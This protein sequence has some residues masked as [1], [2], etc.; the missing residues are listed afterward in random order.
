MLQAMEKKVQAEGDKEEALF[1]KFMCYCNS[2]GGSLEKSIA[3]AGTKIPQVT[4]D[5][6]A[7][8]AKRAQLTEDL[9]TH[10]TDRDAA[11]S[12]MASA[13]AVR[14]KEAAEFA[15]EKSDAETNIAALNKATAAVEAGVAGFVQTD[16]AKVL[17]TF[18]SSDQ[19]IEDS[20][21]DQVL[22][23]LS[24]DQSS[25]GSIQKWLS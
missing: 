20:D 17:K 8:E 10:R 3:D 2:G 11:K 7:G 18:V 24:N 25:A 22:A 1:K 21:R 15:K 6:E 23:F 12:A 14:E 9:K 13:T 5:I 19:K 16:A 4:S